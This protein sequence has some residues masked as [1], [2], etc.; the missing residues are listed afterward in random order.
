[1]MRMLSKVVPAIR[2]EVRDE[3]HVCCKVLVNDKVRLPT[4]AM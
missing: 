4:N 1:M 3:D 2:E